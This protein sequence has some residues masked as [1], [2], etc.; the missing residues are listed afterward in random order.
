MRKFLLTVGV[1]L[2][3]M[4]L[5]GCLPMLFSGVTGTWD[6]VWYLSDGTT[7]NLV[8]T[9]QQSGNTVTGTL[10]TQNGQQLNLNGTISSSGDIVLNFYISLYSYQMKGKVQGTRMSG[11]LLGEGYKI[12]TWEATKRLW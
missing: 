1:V 2:S 5:N 9:L 12:G 8:M 10:T 3:V 6:V 4:I 11:D 7:G